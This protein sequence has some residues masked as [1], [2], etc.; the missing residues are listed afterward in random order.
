MIM[1]PEETVYKKDNYEFE[2]KCFMYKIKK[3]S[4][5]FRCIFYNLKDL[6]H[7]QKMK[8]QIF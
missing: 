8:K 6:L 5:C 2:E 4:P 1:R 7:P 3:K